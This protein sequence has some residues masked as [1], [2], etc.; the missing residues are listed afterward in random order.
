MSFWLNVVGFQLCWF[1]SVLGAANGIPG[2]GP[3]VVGIWLA[4][5]LSMNRTTSEIPL[6]VVAAL[7]GYILDSLLVALGFISFPAHASYGWPSP[8][9][10]VGL[11]AAFAATLR[12]S[13]SWLSYR[14]VIA[15][16]L[17]AIAGPLSYYAGSRLGAIELPAG[18]WSFVGIAVEWAIAMPALYA[19]SNLLRGASVRPSTGTAS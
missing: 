3:L 19:F 2:F 15:S 18:V 14:L 10:M 6:V 1:A 12:W 8:L 5:H 16:A 9:W 13:L 11:W 7:A 4:L 17:G